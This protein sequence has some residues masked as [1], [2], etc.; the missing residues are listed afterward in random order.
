MVSVI[1]AITCISKQTHHGPSYWGGLKSETVHLFNNRTAE[2]RV[3]ARTIPILFLSLPS[4]ITG[5]IL[6]AKQY[7]MSIL[8]FGDA[9]TYYLVICFEHVL[10]SRTV[11]RK[12][13]GHCTCSQ[14]STVRIAYLTG[15]PDLRGV[16]E[17]QVAAR[18]KDHDRR[19]IECCFSLARMHSL[20]TKVLDSNSKVVPRPRRCSVLIIFRSV[21]GELVDDFSE[22]T[23]Y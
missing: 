4:S 17:H 22:C 7:I 18:G 23:R 1:L 13:N 16:R 21:G 14:R 2:A 20:T 15:K 19:Y 5:D 12:I 11:C 8:I 6:R 3:L 10:M 9:L